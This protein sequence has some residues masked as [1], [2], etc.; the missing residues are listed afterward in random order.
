MHYF[1]MLLSICLVKNLEKWFGQINIY[2][3]VVRKFKIEFATNKVK[4][5]KI[6][7]LLLKDFVSLKK[8][9]VKEGTFLKFSL[10]RDTGK[11][12]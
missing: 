10:E 2:S 12:L 4:I 8:E 1:M 7:N 11:V 6:K 5:L 9:S 3:F